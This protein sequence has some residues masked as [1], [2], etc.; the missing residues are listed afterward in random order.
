MIIK[1]RQRSDVAAPQR[2]TKQNLTFRP[3]ME[4]II[5][6]YKKLALPIPSRRPFCQIECLCQKLFEAHGEN[7]Q[8]K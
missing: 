8:K 1:T 3:T 4:C 7:S 6:M 5:G 2:C